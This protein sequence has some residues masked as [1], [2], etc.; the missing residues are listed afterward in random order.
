MTRV[1]DSGNTRTSDFRAYALATIVAVVCFGALYANFNPVPTGSDVDEIG[2]SLASMS[3]A[4]SAALLDTSSNTSTSTSSA[5]PVPPPADLVD[6]TDSSVESTNVASA[7]ADQIDGRYALQMTI[8]LLEKGETFLKDAHSY[9]ATFAKRER[10]DGELSDTQVMRMKIR[11]APYSV[12]MKW[13]V[14]DKGRQVLYVEGENDNRMTVKLGGLK[15][16]FLPAINLDPYGSR[17]MAASRHPITEAGILQIVK[18]MLK[19]RRE[20]LY[21]MDDLT[22]CY[23]DDK[24]YNNRSCYQ[25]EV[26]YANKQACERYRKCTVLIDQE[27]GVPVSI[28]NYGWLNDT[29]PYSEDTLIEEYAFTELQFGERLAAVNFDRGNSKYRMR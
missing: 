3:A 15:G 26:E 19:N 24:S 23:R 1:P 21:R 4:D 8:L 16:R 13:L 11:N 18:K 25:F 28:T 9:S 20:D 14:G 2:Y 17:A 27:F 6:T 5:G 22:F 29:E 7:E 12:Y 10:I